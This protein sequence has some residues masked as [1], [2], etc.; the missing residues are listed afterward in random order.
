MRRILIGERNFSST[1]MDD[2]KGYGEVIEFGSPDA[3]SRNV[4]KA[5]VLI[6]ALEVRLDKSLLDRAARLKLIGSRT[7]QLR[8]I[9]LEI[10][11]SRGIKV[12]NIRADS[13]V[14]R[15]TPSTAEETM[16]L[17]FALTRK[18]PWA[19][20]SI[21]AGKWKRMDYCGTELSGKRVGLIGF[22]RLGR[23]VAR[24]CRA[25]NARVVAYDPHVGAAQVKRFGATKVTLDRL[26]KSCDIVSVHSIYNDKTH[27]LLGAEHFGKMKKGS[28]FINTARGEITDEKALL[29]VLRSG[30]L[31]GAAIDT[32]AGESPDGSHL[33]RNALVRWAKNNENLIIV[34]HLGGAT[35]EAIGRTQR[36]ITDLVIQEM[37][38]ADRK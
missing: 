13:T 2:L 36:Y 14:L 1:A 31:A 32:L 10:C 9:D 25:F 24:F 7:T 17:I 26:L 4:S 16:A 35:S 30:Q 27:G 6:T 3:F 8:Y 22:G 11:A 34:P 18:L 38:S 15:Q 29:A 23:M 33:K 37:R 12:V 21:K 28:I 19:F 20:D 5:D